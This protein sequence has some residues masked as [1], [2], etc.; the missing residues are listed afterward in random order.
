MKH[1]I[2][3]HRKYSKKKKTKKKK[4]DEEERRRRAAAA[5]DPPDA[6]KVG[7][8]AEEGEGLVAA[9]LV[10]VREGGEVPR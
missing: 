6:S 8:L 4:A 5:G 2:L 7:L 1:T 10:A 9:N 3:S